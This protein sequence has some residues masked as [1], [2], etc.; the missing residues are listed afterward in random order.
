C[1]CH[2][3]VVV[4]HQSDLLNLAFSMKMMEHLRRVV[5]LRSNS[6]HHCSRCGIC[7]RSCS[8]CPDITHEV[9]NVAWTELREAVFGPPRQCL[10]ESF[11]DDLNDPLVGLGKKLTH[12]VFPQPTVGI[13]PEVLPCYL[14]PSAGDSL[15]VCLNAVLFQTHVE[16]LGSL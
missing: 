12:H 11:S 13:L 7:C 4:A 5:R 8:L 16:M 10:A 2:P 3:V 6:H 14:S 15:R 1:L 9:V